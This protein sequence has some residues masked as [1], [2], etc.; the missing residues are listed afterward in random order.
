MNSILHSKYM[1]MVSQE[2]RDSPNSL[3]GF[4]AGITG[5]ATLHVSLDKWVEQGNEQEKA[6]WDHTGAPMCNEYIEQ[7]LKSWV[8]LNTIFLRICIL[9]VYFEICIKALNV[10]NSNILCFYM[11]CNTAFWDID[12]KQPPIY[13]QI[14][15][16]VYRTGL[17]ASLKEFCVYWMR[18]KPSLF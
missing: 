11:L 15:V 9:V 2:N 3:G 18:E 10:F 6:L 16:L 4:V 13:R 14:A 8:E 7:K 17:K 12:T 5:K 1:H